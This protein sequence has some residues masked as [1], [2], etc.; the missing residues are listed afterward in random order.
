MMRYYQPQYLAYIGFFASVV[1]AFQ[2][3]MFGYIL[4]KYVFILALPIDT[5]EELEEYES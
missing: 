2:L 4:S 5:P 3:P 1:N